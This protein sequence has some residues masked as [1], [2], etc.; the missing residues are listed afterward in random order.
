YF[1]L[2]D[3]EERTKF[4]DV[5]KN[6]QVGAVFHYIPLHNSPAVKKFCRTQGDLNLTQ[7]ISDRLARLPL[8]VG[9]DKKL[10]LV[11]A[12]VKETI[13]E[14]TGGQLMKGIILAGG[15]GTSLSPLT[16]VT[17]IHLLP[18]GK[19][20]MIWHPRPPTCWLGSY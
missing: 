1:L 16:E 13:N 14:I 5:L 8:W 6:K 10:D 15:K 2:K 3:L 18:V 9:L 7:E 20:P 12:K 11:I 19:E 4:I 17:N